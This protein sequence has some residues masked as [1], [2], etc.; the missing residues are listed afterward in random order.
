MLTFKLFVRKTIDPEAI[1]HVPYF[2][3]AASTLSIKKNK[4][5]ALGLIYQAKKQCISF[6]DTP[7]EANLP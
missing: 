2:H 7:P 6:S 4:I 5:G 3:L 1:V